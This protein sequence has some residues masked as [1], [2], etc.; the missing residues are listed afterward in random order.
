MNISGFDPPYDTRRWFGN[1]RA[2]AARIRVPEIKAAFTAHNEV[3]RR[4]SP[5]Q[6]ADLPRD[7]PRAN[8]DAAACVFPV[9]K[10]QT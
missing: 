8:P 7:L 9:R 10:Y 6:N 5:D 2:A 4:L 1:G 3:L